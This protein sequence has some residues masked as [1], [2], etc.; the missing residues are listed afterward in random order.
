MLVERIRVSYS[1]S[2]SGDNQ[3]L[4]C[5]FHRLSICSMKGCPDTLLKYMEGS[6]GS[7][8]CDAYVWSLQNH[9]FPSIVHDLHFALGDL[10]RVPLPVS[11]RGPLK[12]GWHPHLPAIEPTPEVMLG[13]TVVL[14]EILQHVL[15]L[16]NRVLRMQAILD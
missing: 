10:E 12:P 2:G 14:R 5:F 8:L 3:V 9:G 13:M 16:I 6:S 15:V 1:F 7:R 11:L 4:F